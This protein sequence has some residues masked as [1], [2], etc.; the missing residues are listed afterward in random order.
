MS[1]ASGYAPVDGPPEGTSCSFCGI[2][3]DPQD[4]LGW[5]VGQDAAICPKCITIGARSVPK[6][7]ESEGSA[8]DP[9]G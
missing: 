9:S 3:L 8:P 5:M 6:G 1:F 2:P 4:P 7:A